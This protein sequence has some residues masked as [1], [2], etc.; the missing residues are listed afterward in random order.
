MN[1]ERQHS[2]GNRPFEQAF[3]GQKSQTPRA[4]PQTIGDIWPHYLEGG[5]FAS[6][7]YLQRDYV[8][9]DKVEPLIKA[10]A[11]SEPELTQHQLRRFFQHCRAVEARLRARQ[12]TWA[13]SE[14]EFC[15][16]DAAAADAAGKNPPKIPALF[17]DFIRR[18]VAAVHSEKEFLQGFLPH[19][20]A[21]VGFGSLHLKK[22]DRN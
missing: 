20:E 2:F 15:K 14:A 16:L 19:F 1:K 5:Y 10:M 3:G 18:N 12:S 21:L 13:T 6:E 9:R 22:S 11:R 7:G 4:A 8:S 17:H